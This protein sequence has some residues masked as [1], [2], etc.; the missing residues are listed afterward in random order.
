MQATFATEHLKTFISFL[1]ELEEEINILVHQDMLFA[2]NK[3]ETV[4]I[5]VM[6]VREK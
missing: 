3:D 4:K 2:Y 6:G 5:V 1:D